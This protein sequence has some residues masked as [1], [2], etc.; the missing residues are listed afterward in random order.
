MPEYPPPTPESAT[1]VQ[2]RLHEVARLL[3]GV[4]HLG[5]N[6]QQAL[7]ELTDELARAVDSGALP[8][9]EVAHITEST[10]LLLEALRQRQDR[11]F[12][13][14]ARD[15]LERTLIGVETRAPLASGLA[16]RLLD[17]LADVGI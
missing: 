5:P 11:P 14:G 12:L 15:R 7:A 13:A 9:A 4:D 16:R 6:A 1:S 3:R 10:A 8:P 2:A 17:A